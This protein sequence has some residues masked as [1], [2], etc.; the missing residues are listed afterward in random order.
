[1][2][3][4]RDNLLTAPSGNLLAIAPAAQVGLETT[5]TAYQL[6]KTY[7][8]ESASEIP[9]GSIAGLLRK[10]AWGFTA[11]FLAFGWVDFFRALR[12]AREGSSSYSKK[13]KREAWANVAVSFIS[14][15]G[16]TLA[17][18]FLLA[19]MFYVAPYIL[20]IVLGAS[21]LQ[22][23]Y[24]VVSN[25][26]KAYQNQNKAE[27]RK[28]LKQAGIAA[29]QMVF[30]ALA[31]TLNILI[32]QA[33]ALIA[34]GIKE[35]ASSF[36]S[37]IFHYA[38]L[39]NFIHGP[40]AAAIATIRGVG[41]AWLGLFAVSLTAFFV[42]L[43]RESVQCMKGKKPSSP[44]FEQEAW[45]DMRSIV[46]VIKDSN[47]SLLLRG[48]LVLTAPLTLP[49]YFTSLVLHAF[50]LRP[51]AAITIGIPQFILG[52][53]YQKLKQWWN[54]RK[55]KRN[56]QEDQVRQPLLELKKEEDELHLS[57]F[58][59]LHEKHKKEVM[60]A[61]TKE[62]AFTQKPLSPKHKKRTWNG[63]KF[64]SQQTSNAPTDE[65]QGQ[66]SQ[67]SKQPGC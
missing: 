8:P 59:G 16:I 19:G 26:T 4:S 23:L 28:H 47:R 52:K 60:V 57:S 61:H 11:L 31:L 66:Y 5:E 7:S 53:A 45:A 29:F 32:F 49:L 48:V 30:N 21:I 54:S 34:G 67:V 62:Q 14:A 58:P 51:V 1:M 38:D 27:R 24:Y 10:I 65:G 42:K 20:A 6:A 13:E 46:N 12:K 33:A 37:I 25:L 35:F 63:S 56:L 9:L 41:F 15:A 43:N 2:A 17:L 39:M 50:V 64:S 55:A 40:V 22:G 3:T 36:I 44:T 18:G